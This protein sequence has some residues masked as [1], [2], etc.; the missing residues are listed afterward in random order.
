MR[1]INPFGLRM[2]A[3]LKQ[4]LVLAAKNNKRSLN[5]EIIVRLERSLEE[6]KSS[7]A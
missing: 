2:N 1:S 4:K 6:P 3:E 7:E 5:A